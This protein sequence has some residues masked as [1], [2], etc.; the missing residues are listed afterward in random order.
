MRSQPI[1][2]PTDEY[3]A[4]LTVPQLVAVFRAH[5]GR[6]NEIDSVMLVN[7]VVCRL[8]DMKGEAFVE[9]LYHPK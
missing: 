2:Q 8:M 4:T 5:A 9:K 1:A 7:R 3:L 6:V